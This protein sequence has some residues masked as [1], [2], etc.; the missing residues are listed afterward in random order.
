MLQKAAKFASSY[1]LKR[2]MLHWQH[3]VWDVLPNMEA[4]QLLNDLISDRFSE[5]LS[6]CSGGHSILKP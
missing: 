6:E 1:I 4:L 2:C 3:L 5:M